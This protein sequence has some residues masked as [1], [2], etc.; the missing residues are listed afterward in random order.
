MA[1][2]A[3]SPS[4]PTTAGEKPL[5]ISASVVGNWALQ[6]RFGATDATLGV[7]PSRLSEQAATSS[8]ATSGARAL[9]VT[10]AYR[11]PAVPLKRSLGG[12]PE[13]SGYAGRSAR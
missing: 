4:A 13:Y 2:P 7:G 11:L 3:S 8:T 6:M 10:P 5:P 9:M 12:H 1:T